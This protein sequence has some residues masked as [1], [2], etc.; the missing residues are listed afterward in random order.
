MH[1]LQEQIVYI[2]T[3]LKNYRTKKYLFFL[4]GL[5]QYLIEM[6]D[7]KDNHKNSENN[8][9]NNEGITGKLSII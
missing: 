7:N 9:I 4:Q 2:S 8:S 6:A 5:H 3:K 1:N